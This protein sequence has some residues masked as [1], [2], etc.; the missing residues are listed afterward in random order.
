MK[1]GRVLQHSNVEKL[2]TSSVASEELVT[3]QQELVKVERALKRMDQRVEKVKETVARARGRLA[4]MR[5]KDRAQGTSQTKRAVATA[6][7][8][9]EQAREKR[10]SLLSD[11]REMKLMVRDQRLLVR[12]LEKKEVAKQEAVARFLRQ[13]ERDYDRKMRMKARTVHKRRGSI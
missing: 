8:R 4:E 11:Y 5:E 12:G 1:R 10:D 6:R 7:D 3:Q 2:T 13:W 9:L